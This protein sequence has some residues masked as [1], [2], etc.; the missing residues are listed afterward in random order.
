M[1]PV[2]S[3]GP[4]VA[5]GNYKNIWIYF[6]APTLGALAGSGAYTLVKLRD[7]DDEAQ[8]QPLPVRSFSH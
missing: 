2:R 5:T 1:N 4:A 7:D 6:V 3:L 8:Q